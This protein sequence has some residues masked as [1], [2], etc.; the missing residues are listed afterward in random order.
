[1]AAIIVGSGKSPGIVAGCAHNDVFKDRFKKTGKE[2][3]RSRFVNIHHVY[4]WIFYFFIK[5][6]KKMP[7]MATAVILLRIKQITTI[8]YK[9]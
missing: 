1:L 9:K 3:K 2:K 4:Y 6:K 5:C 7:V 8:C